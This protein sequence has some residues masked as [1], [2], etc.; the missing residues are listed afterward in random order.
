MKI[1]F[2]WNCGEDTPFR[3]TVPSRPYKSFSYD[4]AMI[5]NVDGRERGL[6]AE[7]TPALISLLLLF[8]FGGIGGGVNLRVVDEPFPFSSPLLLLPA[9]IGS[10]VTTNFG[11]SIDV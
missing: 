9:T 4:P 10:F 6:S 3:V 2:R 11:L 8:C 1:G 7:C 5:L